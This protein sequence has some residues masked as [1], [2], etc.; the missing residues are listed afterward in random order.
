MWLADHD[1]TEKHKCEELLANKEQ[2]MIS[3]QF[4]K[5]PITKQCKKL[6]KYA[7]LLHVSV[8]YKIRHRTK[9]TWYKI[10]KYKSQNHFCYFAGNIVRGHVVTARALF[11]S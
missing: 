7:I 2:F 6:L 8:N 3:G 11:A 4:K 9:Y 1:T 10:I 5:S